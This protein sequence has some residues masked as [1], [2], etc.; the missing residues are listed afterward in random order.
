MNTITAKVTEAKAYT[1]GLVVVKVW[2][3]K[4]DLAKL[5]V[6]CD[7]TGAIVQIKMQKFE[8]KAWRESGVN[9]PNAFGT[10]Q[11]GCESISR[12][13]LDADPANGRNDDRDWLEVNGFDPSCGKG[14]AAPLPD[15]DDLLDERKETKPAAPKGF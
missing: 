7:G 4:D 8:Y 12:M 14:L 15:F 6:E 10:F 5:G 1:F 11:F 2:V 9:F 3:N 13:H